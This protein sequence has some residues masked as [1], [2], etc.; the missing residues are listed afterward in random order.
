[1]QDLL[2]LIIRGFV[3]AVLVISVLVV[4]AQLTSGSKASTTISQINDIAAHVRKAYLTQPDFTGLNC[5]SGSTCPLIDQK[6]I[7]S[8]LV[9]SGGTLGYDSW[10]GAI[11]IT[12]TGPN[13]SQFLISA[14]KLGRASCIKVAEGVTYAS[15][16]TSAGGSFTPGTTSELTPNSID[17]AC[18]QGNNNLLTFTFDR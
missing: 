17:A 3:V 12:A 13:D 6:A 11:T 4:G 18:A 1:M 15:L 5:T 8:N 14:D 10:G 7:P 9:T 2:P 16:T